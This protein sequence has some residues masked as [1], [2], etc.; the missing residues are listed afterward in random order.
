MRPVH[1]RG[2]SPRVFGLVTITPMTAFR[3]PRRCMSA[4]CFERRGAQK[5]PAVLVRGVEML[6]IGVGASNAL[7][8]ANGMPIEDDAGGVA[9]GTKCGID[10]DTRDRRKRVAAKHKRQPAP[11]PRRNARVVQQSLDRPAFTTGSEG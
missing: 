2:L 8:R 3:A 6:R 7:S 9:G 10:A 1:S 11:L 4:A 5:R